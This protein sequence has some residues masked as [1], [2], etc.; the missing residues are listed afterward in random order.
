[1]DFG[2]SKPVDYS[3]LDYSNPNFHHHEREA[4]LHGANPLKR[5]SSAHN[6][7]S[8]GGA[9]SETMAK[10][11]RRSPPSQEFLAAAAGGKHRLPVD[12]SPSKH[13]GRSVVG[14]PPNT[15]YDEK[16]RVLEGSNGGTGGNGGEQ[17]RFCSI[18][19][20]DA[21][22]LCSGCRKVWYCSQDCQVKIKFIQFNTSALTGFF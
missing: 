19:S 14:E 21:Q 8:V 6:A 15:N 7:S 9:A 2:R 16:W 10:F 5:P 20:K 1:M 18:C 13:P 4:A 12:P 11:Q 3:F 22:Y 17:K